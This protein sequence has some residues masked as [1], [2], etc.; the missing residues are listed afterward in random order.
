MSAQ[1][2]QRGFSHTSQRGFTTLEMLIAMGVLGVILTVAA[3][4]L[5]T[6]QRVSD[7]QQARTNS[8]EDARQAASRMAETINQAAY[9]YPAGQSIQ[10]DDGLVGNTGKNRV[11]TG[12]DA[13]ALL[14]PEGSSASRSYRGVVFY[15]AARTAFRDDLPD[16]PSS[17]IAQSV[18]VEARSSTTIPWA[19]NQSSP[20]TAIW[21]VKM[22][23][24]VLVDGMVEMV[25]SAKNDCSKVGSSLMCSASFSPS[26]GIDQTAFSGGLRADGPSINTAKALL[27]GVS[28]KLAIRVSPVG[29]TATT[30]PTTTITSLGTARNVPRR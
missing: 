11:M 8:L 15:L 6:N 28:F 17:R 2:S 10:V 13:L 22:D 20:P 1:I 30:S 29:Q 14:L 4:L 25:E 18:L 16:I 23:E 7:A 9:I 21:N 24:G 12:K 5:Q 26:A 19:Q 3:A 27:L